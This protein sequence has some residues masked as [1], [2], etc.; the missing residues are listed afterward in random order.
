M[1]TASAVNRGVSR[2]RNLVRVLAEFIGKQPPRPVEYDWFTDAEVAGFDSAVDRGLAKRIDDAT[3]RDLEGKRYLR[4]VAEGSSILDRQM[5]FHRLRSGAGSARVR[6]LVELGR[7]PIGAAID[8]VRFALRC[9]E[10]D[11]TELFRG[12]PL[13]FPA[14]ATR[15]KVLPYVSGVAALLLFTEYWLLALSLLIGC[16]LLGAA[17]HLHFYG[18]IAK[19]QAQRAALLA[20]LRCGLMLVEL[21]RQHRTPLLDEVER[22]HA[23]LNALIAEFSPGWVARTPGLAQYLNLVALHDFLE[24]LKQSAVVERSRAELLE[25]YQSIASF[26]ADVC[27]IEHLA[28][29]PNFCWPQVVRGKN[30]AL[31]D[32]VNPLLRS[33]TP[34]SMELRNSGAFISGQNGAGKSTWLRAVGLNLLSARGFGFCYAASASLPS[35]P[36][37]SSLLNEDSLVE[38]VSLYMAELARAEELARVAAAD[39]DAVILIDEPFRGTNRDES[40]AVAA[41]LLSSLAKRCLVLVS[42]HNLLL[43]PLLAK[44]LTAWRLASDAS[45]R[46][47]LRFEPGILL[48]TNGLELMKRYDFDAEVVTNAEL[49]LRWLTGGAAENRL[50]PEL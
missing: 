22:Q 9:I 17:V 32:S 45:D 14:W 35:A 5:L 4:L 36:V 29:V 30:L 6:A 47:E 46:S 37:Y 20:V 15:L 27:L 1:V 2:I 25:I 41:G 48:E 31:V 42:S 11:V 44:H 7:R 16:L 8:R 28:S 49:V 43:A 40:T 26:E 13:T 10:T 50:I 24:L 3:W 23:R 38:G 19:W 18:A 21:Q 34:L 39:G 33:A 12:A